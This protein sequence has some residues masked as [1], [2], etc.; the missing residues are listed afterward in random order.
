MIDYYMYLLLIIIFFGDEMFL[1]KIHASK[2]KP[3]LEKR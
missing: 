1:N 3:L 2:N